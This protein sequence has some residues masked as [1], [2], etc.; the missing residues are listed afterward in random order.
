M[1]NF[2]FTLM[3]G[4]F[5]LAGCD[6]TVYQADG[7]SGNTDTNTTTDANGTTEIN[8]TSSDTHGTTETSSTSGDTNGN[9]DTNTTTDANGTTETNSTTI[10]KKEVQQ[11]ENAK[12]WYVRLIV[13]DT[14]NNLI[15]TDAQLGELDAADMTSHALKAISPFTSQYLDVL[16]MN[17][18]GVDAGAYKSDFH[19]A[20]TDA[21][22]WDFTVKSFDSNATLILSWRGLYVLR[23]YKDRQNRTRYYE[24]RSST[25]PLLK[26]M[27]L[28]DVTNG[29]EVEVLNHGSA[30]TYVFDMNGTNERVF[31]WKIKD[32]SI[33]VQPKFTSFSR[34]VA[35]PL[36]QAEKLHALQVKALRKDAKATPT[37]L[38]QKRAQSIDMRQPPQFKVIA[39]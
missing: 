10:L 23:P 2:I 37:K 22:V 8:N 7:S 39:P 6:N 27:T 26:Y 24:Y 5:F 32:S 18:V 13:E 38:Q 35:K 30:E 25:N 20:S 14:T 19:S 15:S 9:T 21:D 33:V 4:L 12:E 1:K 31:R 29:K 36:K 3:I 16:F 28:Y 11:E 34:V 17:P